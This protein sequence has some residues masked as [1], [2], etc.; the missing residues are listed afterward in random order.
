[1]EAA[2]WEEGKPLP[3]SR[4]LPNNEALQTFL[5]DGE[6]VSSCLFSCLVVCCLLVELEAIDG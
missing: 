3:G 6:L 2:G 4:D 1:M 5:T